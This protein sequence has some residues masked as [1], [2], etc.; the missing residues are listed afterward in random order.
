MTEKKGLT[1]GIIG[2]GA[3]VFRALGV[4][5]EVLPSYPLAAKPEVVGSHGKAYLC[6]RAAG[7]KQLGVKP[8][9]DACL[10]H[11]IVEAPWAH[12]AWHSYSLVLI[13]LR[14]MADRRKTLIYL[15]GATHELWLYAL[16]PEK[17]R[18]PMQKTGIVDCWLNPKNF[19]AQFIEISD[20]LA[21]KRVREAVMSI[22]AGRLNPDTDARQQWIELFGN[23][24]MK[25]R[26]LRRPPQE[27]GGVPNT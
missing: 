4:S 17:D 10:D 7:Y 1:V 25:D 26:P 9:Q 22:C 5:G 16:D 8:E 23:N 18:N 19:S 6:D 20:D 15:D 21:R 11:W 3:N 27:F 24:M 13:H 14:P 12:P 2:T